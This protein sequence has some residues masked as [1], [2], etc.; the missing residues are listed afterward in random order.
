MNLKELYPLETA[1]AAAL[2]QVDISN[3]SEGAAL[4][5]LAHRT[6]AKP[7]PQQ[8]L[9]VCRPSHIVETGS[10]Y[11]F[12]AITNYDYVYADLWA[13]Q[14]TPRIRRL[15]CRLEWAASELA[16]AAEVFNADDPTPIDIDKLALILKPRNFASKVRR[17]QGETS[18]LI[19]K[20]IE[21]IS[22][23]NGFPPTLDQVGESV[24]INSATVHRHVQRLKIAGL[25]LHDGPRTLRLNNHGHTESAVY[26]EG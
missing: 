23:K 19:L 18:R 9:A 22:K 3:L 26:E 4:L 25:V 2:A 5:L 8:V 16:S 12:N 10:F 7:T 1:P 15:V 24:G 11:V 6:G 17:P 21:E 14:G 20:A 13:G